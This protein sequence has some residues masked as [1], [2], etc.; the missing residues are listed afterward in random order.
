[1]FIDGGSEVQN[2]KL[3]RKDSKGAWRNYPKEKQ[4]LDTY[5]QEMKQGRAER[6][7]VETNTEFKI[8]YLENSN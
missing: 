6:V 2:W 1:M 8:I 5:K 3:E 4:D 7:G